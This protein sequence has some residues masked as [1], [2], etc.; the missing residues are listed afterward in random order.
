MNLFVTGARGRLASYLVPY[1]RSQG[2]R[3]KTF[4]RNGSTEHLPLIQI[5]EEMEKNYPDALL[6]LAWSTVPALSEQL[7]GFEWEE[8][9]ALV[10]RLSRALLQKRGSRKNAARFVFFS[11]CSV[12]GLSGKK[13]ITEKD[14]PE[15]IGWYAQAKLAAENLL[16]FFHKKSNLPVLIL[17]ISNPYGFVQDSKSL[18]GVIPAMVRAA[19]GKKTFYLWG[20]PKIKKDFIHVRELSEA[21]ERCLRK[22]I[23]GK[24]NVCFGKSILLKNL[25]LEIRRRFGNFNIRETKIRAWDIPS[26]VY[27]NNKFCKAVAW[28][29]KINL[30]RGLALLAKDKQKKTFSRTK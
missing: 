9:L 19:S 14:K 3:V 1:L 27:K 20:N 26:G 8:D 24:Y 12:Y 6:H 5:E 28:R 29:P 25:I 15:P 16:E 4:S 13:A 7:A 21:L 30:Y 2:Y 11:S 18:Q 17:R 10:A 23:Q 22:N